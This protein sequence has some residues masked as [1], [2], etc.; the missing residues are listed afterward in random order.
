MLFRTIREFDCGRILGGVAR[1]SAGY[2][3]GIGLCKAPYVL[4]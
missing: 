4:L 3:L 2:L 1:D